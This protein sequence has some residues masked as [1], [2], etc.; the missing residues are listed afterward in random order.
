[1]APAPTVYILHGEDD[2]AISEFLARLIDKL[3]DPTSAQLNLTQVVGDQADLADVETACHSAPFLAS[4]RLVIV[5]PLGKMG[6][7]FTRLVQLLENLPPTTGLVLVEAKSLGAESPLLRWAESH[8][9]QA[10]V[11]SFQPPRGAALVRWIVQRAE[12]LGGQIQPAAAD[13]L[14]DSVAGDDRTAAQELAKLLDFVDRRRAVTPED[15][16]S[17]TPVHGQSDIFAMVD[18]LGQR[19][20][21]HALLHLH[22][23]L[24]V[25][26]PRYIFAMVIRQFRLLLLARE[27]LDAGKS[28]RQALTLPPFVADKVAGQAV[29]FSLDRLEAIYHDLLDIDL[30]SK[31]GRA[32]LDVALDTLVVTLAR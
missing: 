28:P 2:L 14:A 15:V 4:R 23:L 25:E 12:R 19:N 26:E 8:G 11:R 21:R 18:A 32:D 6:T 5:R 30:A 9:E 24:E 10:F 27:A 1:M 3:G 31:R 16:E 20:G 29:N 22:R 13:L 17:V 7:P